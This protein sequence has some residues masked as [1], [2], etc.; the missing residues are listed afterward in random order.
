MRPCAIWVAAREDVAC[1]QCNARYRLKGLLLPNGTPYAGK[2]AWTAAL[3]R[4]LAKLALPHAAQQSPS[5][6]T[7]APLLNRARASPG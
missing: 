4:W 5:R 3:Q 1:E 7:C 6:S 2:T